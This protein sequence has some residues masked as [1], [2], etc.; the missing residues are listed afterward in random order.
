MHGAEG[1][2]RA[3]DRAIDKHAR[4]ALKRQII[5]R[6]DARRDADLRQT[7]AVLEGPFAYLF[8][9]IRNLDDCHRK[10]LKGALL[11]DLDC[12]G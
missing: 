6:S 9:A 1:L 5:D 4:A 7:L 11:Y 2:S 3:A 8:A 12:C 10:T